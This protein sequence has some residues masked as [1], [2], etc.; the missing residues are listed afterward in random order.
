MAEII[1]FILALDGKYKL[2][3]TEYSKTTLCALLKVSAI[4]VVPFSV[5]LSQRLD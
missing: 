5:L 4:K 3:H 1:K 2:M